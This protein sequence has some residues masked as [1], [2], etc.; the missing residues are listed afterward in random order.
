[1]YN[2][3]GKQGAELMAVETD[4]DGVPTKH[5]ILSPSKYPQSNDG[6]RASSPRHSRQNSDGSAV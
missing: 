3:G 2:L 4:A 1:M 6:S 5:L